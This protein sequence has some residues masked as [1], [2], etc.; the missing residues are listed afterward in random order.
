MKK[1]YFIVL[2]GF[3]VLTLLLSSC[4]N[5]LDITLPQGPKGEQGEKGDKGDKGDPGLSAFELWLQVNEKDPST[6]IEDFFNS[7]RGNDGQDGLVPVIGENGNWFI[8]EEDT[9]IP[10]RGVNGENGVTP[11]IGENGN[12]FIGGE[13]TGVPARGADGENGVDGK[14]AYELW[15]DAVDQGEMTNKDGS[16]YTGGNTW[17][18]FLVWLQGGDVSVLHRYWLTLPGNE[19]KTIEEFIDELFDC[20][21]D[22]I[23]VSLFYEDECMAQNN[24]GTLT[25]A[26]NAQLRVG[27]PGGTQ[28]QVT[29]EG[30]DLTATI[31]DDTTP[32]QFTIPR[33]EADIPLT[34]TCTQS[35][36]TV[37]KQSVVPALQLVKLADV[38]TAEQ[39][40]GEEAEVVSISFETAPVELLVNDT[41]VYDASG[42]VEGSG[43][44]VSNE[45]KTFTRTY[46]RGTLEQKPTVRAFNSNGVCT[47]I[48]EAF[49]IP[50]LTPVEVGELTLTIIDDCFL[51]LSFTGTPGMS[52]RA[53]NAANHAMFVDLTEVTPGTYITSEIP[54]RYEAFSVLVRAQ[55][56]GRSTVERTF[57]VNGANLS[58]VAEPLTITVTPGAEDGVDHSFVQRRFTNNTDAPLTVNVTRSSNTAVGA[59]SHPSA[60]PYPRSTVI[61]ANSY[62]DASFYR[63]YTTTL[64]E[65]QYVLTFN[66][67]T[68]CGLDRAYTLAILNQGNYRYSIV[69]LNGWGDGTG[70]PN[71]LVTF[72]ISIFDGIP[73]SYVEFQVFNGTMYTGIT[74]VQLDAQGNLTWTVT[75]TRAQ[76]QTALDNEKGF[77]YFFS[78]SNYVNKY[79]IGASKE[80]IVFTWN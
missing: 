11:V 43:W 9:G 2:S 40:P 79:N 14:S 20:H 33:G 70:N 47:T 45:G 65:G 59:S 61:P 41:V 57:E 62:I 3:I 75:G 12:W 32:V 5:S 67:I 38:P 80:E 50:P 73:G 24:D 19:G 34:I 35:N 7:L 78:D 26:Y 63:D 52:V 55:M 15:K 54:R 76:V 36:G 4:E 27:G 17:E 60:L 77:F 8:G 29:G 58:P 74:R 13:D 21:C 37:V 22:G 49:T 42:I 71:D 66:T 30:V 69:P 16:D 18:D 64:A 39:V 44:A 1:N 28:V 72:E 31:L 48:E 23:T 6:P 25:Q 46:Q 68:E 10:A 51:S 56:D 53:M